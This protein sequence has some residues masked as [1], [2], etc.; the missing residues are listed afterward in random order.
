MS[1]VKAQAVEEARS[2]ADYYHAHRDE[3]AE[4]NREALAHDV[5]CALQKFWTN[6]YD[7]GRKQVLIAT[8]TKG[9]KLAPMRGK[10]R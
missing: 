5:L 10:K 2:I 3:D 9:R 8:I 4:I 1:T 7:E 6:G